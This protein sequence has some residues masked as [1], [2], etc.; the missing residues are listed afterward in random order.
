MY[1]SGS[2]SLPSVTPHSFLIYSPLICQSPHTSAVFQR[3]PAHTPCVALRCARMELRSCDPRVC[4]RHRR[5]ASG[6]CRRVRPPAPSL[7]D[8]D[9]LSIF[10]LTDVTLLNT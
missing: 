7:P 1:N 9:P 8:D 4:P 3:V 10:T 6:T 5:V 2:E